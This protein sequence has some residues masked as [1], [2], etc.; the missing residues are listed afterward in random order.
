[1][2]AEISGV[3]IFPEPK[4]YNI[5]NGPYVKFIEDEMTESVDCSV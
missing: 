2:S 5:C 3:P 1:M 4:N